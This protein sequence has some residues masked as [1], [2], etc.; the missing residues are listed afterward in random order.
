MPPIPGT[1]KR[2]YYSDSASDES[3]EDTSDDDELE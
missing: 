1:K 2:G 3:G